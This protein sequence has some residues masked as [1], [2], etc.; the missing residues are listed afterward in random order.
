M[1]KILL[2]IAAL[3]AAFASAADMDEGVLVLT[4]KNFD[5]ELAKHDSLLVEFYAPWCGHCKKLAPEYAS[6][7][8]TLAKQDPPQYL[9]KVDA[10]E[11]NALAER[12]EIK[13]FPT[14]IFFRGGARQDYTGGRTADTIVSWVSKKTGPATRAVSCADISSETSGKLAAV[15]WGDVEGP[16][17]SKIYTDVAKQS[18][19]F[20]FLTAPAD[21]AAAHGA[22]A[23]GVSAFRT[24]DESP[25]HYSGDHTFGDLNQ[26]FET[27]SIP[28]LITFSEDYIEP[29]FGKGNNALILFSDDSSAAYNAVFEK[30]ANELNGQIL[31]VKSGT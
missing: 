27:A 26:W 22:S 21:C 9:A 12:F 10:T 18:E 24:F 31:F 29:I 14:L 8:A 30:A 20:V 15:Y 11:N 4:D 5:E 1:R 28:K 23:P 13:G 19:K 7:A 6:A 17:L 25:I 3:F 16:A 2:T